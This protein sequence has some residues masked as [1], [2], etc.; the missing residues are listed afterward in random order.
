M[1]QSGVMFCFQSLLS[2]NYPRK[3]LSRTYQTVKTITWNEVSAALRPFYF[4]VH[5]DKFWNHPIEKQT[6]EHSLKQLNAYIEALLHKQNTVPLRLSFYVRLPKDTTDA[7]SPQEFRNVHIKLAS[8]NVQTTVREV[9][10]SCSLSTA[11]LNRFT[12]TEV[13]R[14]APV[15]D[16]F[17]DY[18]YDLRRSRPGHSVKEPGCRKDWTVEGRDG[19][20]LERFLK[21][22]TPLARE[23]S[24]L[25]LPV[26]EETVRL[27]REIVDALQLTA[28]RWD[29]G[30]GS[31]HF[32]GCLESFKMLS[33][34]HPDVAANLRGRTV[35]LGRTTG[36][37]LDGHVVLNIE[38]VRHNWLSL[39]RSLPRYDAYVSQVP[40]AERD[41]SDTLRGISVEHRKFKPAVAAQ[42][43]VQQLQ[44]LTVALHRCAAALKKLRGPA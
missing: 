22:N 13:E 29:C 37:S 19:F 39:L 30:W 24:A 1:T 7:A 28:V 25:S 40:I 26:R 3:C 35:V 44:K 18:V 42:A 2:W 43:Y 36:V 38:E 6:N 11:H 21:E 5:P 16:D 10:S 33:A 8:K 20:D 27:S 34:Q 41:L 32:R 12:P 31:G 23:R 17:D 15:L 4:I 9:L 14:P